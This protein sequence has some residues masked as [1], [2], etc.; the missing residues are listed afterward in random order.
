MTLK[1]YVGTKYVWGGENFIGI[2]C[3]GL[4]RR[5]MIVAEIRRG[6]LHPNPTLVRNGLSLWW[7]D[8]TAKTLM[9]EDYPMTVTL[10][11]YD[12]INKV[13][14]NSTITSDVASLVMPGDIAVTSDG[15][16]ALANVGPNKWI[17]A[18][19]DVGKVIVVKT[20]SD[21]I[22]FNTPVKILRWRQLEFE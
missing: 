3:S 20:P 1:S 13:D 17:E 8:T 12:S 18:D 21:S 14:E 4:L 2:D 9:S 6:L 11:T 7:N 22:W 5:A 16:H 10:F 15:V 19:P